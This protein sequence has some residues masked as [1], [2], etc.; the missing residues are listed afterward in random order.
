MLECIPHPFES[1]RLGKEKGL[2]SLPL[3]T[4]VLAVYYIISAISD[5]A[6]GFAFNRFDAEKL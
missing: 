1:F 4:A 2:G 6:S 5:K 3:A